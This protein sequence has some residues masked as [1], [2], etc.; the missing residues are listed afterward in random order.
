MMA[1]R[2]PETKEL[3]SSYLR[4]KQKSTAELRIDDYLSGRI[5]QTEYGRR[6]RADV[7]RTEASLLDKVTP[8]PVSHQ[9]QLSLLRLL[10]SLLSHA[11]SIEAIATDTENNHKDQE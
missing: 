4:A 7:E 11:K 8:Y 10:Q 6:L 9:R 3:P 2:E 1:E 5:T